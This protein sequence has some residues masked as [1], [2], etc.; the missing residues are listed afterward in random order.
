[1]FKTHSVLVRLVNGRQGVTY[2]QAL[3]V[4]SHDFFT[5]GEPQCYALDGRLG[6]GN[7]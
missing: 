6:E 2:C 1:M 5:M 3:Q 4:S 7:L